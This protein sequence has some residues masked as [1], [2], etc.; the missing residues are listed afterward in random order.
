MARSSRK[1]KQKELIE[2]EL[3]KITT[4]FSADDI[5]SKI[6]KIDSSIGI[7][8]IY[9]F[10]KELEEKDQI[11][12]YICDRR[13]VYSFNKNSHCHFTC[14]KTGKVIHF[15]IDNIDFLKNK[16]PGKIISFQLDVKG[17]CEQCKRK[18]L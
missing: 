18:C 9:R 3:K 17:V 2:R 7:A 8:T 5:Y 12:Y 14:E 6:K 1:T 16:I 15:E 4:F 13:K 10:L 11:F